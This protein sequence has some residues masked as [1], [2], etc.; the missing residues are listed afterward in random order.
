M[1]EISHRGVDLLYVIYFAMPRFFDRPLKEK[2]ITVFHE[3][4][5]VSEQFDGDI[6]RFS[7]RN[8]AHG[9]ST[10]KYNRLMERFVDEYLQG[11][12]AKELTAFLEHGM[13]GLREKHRAI[14]GRRMTMPKV[15]V[16]KV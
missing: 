10:K 1:P 5:H 14:V 15:L 9:G 11:S 16:E 7:G 6:R 3:L 13:S 4:Y 8:Y 2:L 12:A